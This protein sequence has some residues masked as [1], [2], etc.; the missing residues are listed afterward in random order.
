MLGSARVC[1][2]LASA[3]SQSRT[4]SKF[5][6]FP[7]LTETVGKIVSAR[8]SKPARETRALPRA[9]SYDYNVP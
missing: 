9:Q 1:R 6:P 4:L 2:V 8:R 7:R 3:S 5:V